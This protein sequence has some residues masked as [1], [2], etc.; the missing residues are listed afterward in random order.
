MRMRFIAAAWLFS[1]VTNLGCAQPTRG[2]V[3]VQGTS[4]QQ[5]PQPIQVVD[6]PLPNAEDSLKFGILGD[7]GTG[8]R[9][10]IEMA[11]EM[12]RVHQRF[13][14]ELVVTVGDNIY[15]S[16][17]P[18]DFDRKFKIPYKPLLDAGVKFYASLGNHDS[19]EQRVYPPF[20]MDDK[21]YYSF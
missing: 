11:A 4:A 8:D 5:K 14:Y 13:P 21:T 3:E 15:G 10:Q 20:N 2:P 18:Q 6:T 19:R 12:A 7:F 16:E 17:R 9:G 1:V